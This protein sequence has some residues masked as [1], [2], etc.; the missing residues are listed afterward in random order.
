MAYLGM[1]DM[2][3]IGRM[4]MAEFYLRLE[5]Y[6][7]RQ[8]DRQE[9]LATLA[10]LNQQVQATTGKSDPQPK[11]RQFDQFF[12]RAGAERQIRRSY[13]DEYVID[14]A[15]DADEQSDSIA[16]RI[17]EYKRL[18]AKGLIDMDAW[19]KEGDAWRQNR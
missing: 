4:T 12:D 9:E 17:A 15:E 10:W 13:G 2:R 14:V 18:K 16:A 19:R 8:L 1:Q 3:E 5:A 6:Q 11:Y 7:L